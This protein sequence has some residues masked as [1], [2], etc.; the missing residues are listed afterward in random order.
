[1][2]RPEIGNSDVTCRVLSCWCEISRLDVENEITVMK[3]LNTKWDLRTLHHVCLSRD[4][5]HIE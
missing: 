5:F 4:C 2:I 3:I 1:M